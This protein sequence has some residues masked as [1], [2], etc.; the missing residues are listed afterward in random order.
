MKKIRLTDKNK[1]RIK[2]ICV[3]VSFVLCLLVMWKIGKPLVKFASEPELFRQWVDNKGIWGRLA[4]IGM[5]VLQV[6]LAFIPGEPFEI[7]GGYAFGPVEGTVLCLIGIFIGSSLTFLLVRLFG[8]K[9]AEVFF[10]KEKLQSLKFLKTS[11]KKEILFLIIYILPGTPK[12]MLGYYVGL[13][14]MTYGT[15][16]LISFFGRIPSVITSTLGGSKLGEKDYF[17]ALIILII[18]LAISLAGLLIYKK[19]CEKHQ[20]RKQ[21]KENAND[22]DKGDRI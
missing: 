9:I 18:T 16:A 14:D 15:W 1:L 7:V 11:Q 5:T 3:I 12:D 8:M 6:L 10:P 20:S 19:I 4:Y 22:T 21:N 13:T 2:R 17:S